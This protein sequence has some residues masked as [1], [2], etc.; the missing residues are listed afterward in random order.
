MIC[1]IIYHANFNLVISKQFGPSRLPFLVYA[2]KLEQ[3]F[4]EQC[5]Y[6]LVM[7]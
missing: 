3:Y 6:I 2:Q 7:D 4:W 5:L 1:F